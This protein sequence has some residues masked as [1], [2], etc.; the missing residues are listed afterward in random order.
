[1]KVHLMKPHDVNVLQGCSYNKTKFCH[2]KVSNLWL[3]MCM[4]IFVCVCVYT[5]VCTCLKGYRVYRSVPGKRPWALYHFSLPWAF[6]QCTG[7][8]PCTKLCTKLV[9]G[10]NAQS[11]SRWRFVLDRRQLAHLYRILDKAVALSLN[12]EASDTKPVNLMPRFSC[13]LADKVD[14]RS[15]QSLA[16]PLYSYIR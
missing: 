14:A 2:T 7:R 5:C 9:G 10:V 8:L 12:T 6:T 13:L 4:F 15:S 3:R 1:M 11:R 16:T